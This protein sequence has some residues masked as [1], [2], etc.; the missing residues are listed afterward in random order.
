M[1]QLAANPRYQ[2]ADGERCAILSLNNPAYLAHSLAVMARR[3]SKTWRL[4]HTFSR[5]LAFCLPQGSRRGCPRDAGVRWCGGASQPLLPRQGETASPRP[6]CCHPSPLA[7][8]HAH[9][10]PPHSF[11]FAW[12]Q[13]AEQ[14]RDVR[15][16]LLLTSA[17]LLEKRADPIGKEAGLS[18]VETFGSHPMLGYPSPWS[19]SWTAEAVPKSALAAPPRTL[20]TNATAL[21]FY[22]SGSTGKPKPIPHTHAGVL[23]WARAYS[24]A[25]PDIFPEGEEASARGGSLSFT[26]Y[27]HV[28]GFVAS[29]AINLVQGRPSYV[30][31]KGGMPLPGLNVELLTRAIDELRPIVLNSVPW[32]VEAFCKTLA[33]GQDPRVRDALDSLRLLTYGGAALKPSCEGVLHLF[34]INATCSYGQTELCGPV[35]LGDL[36]GDMISLRPIGP[37]RALLDDGDTLWPL[38]SWPHGGDVPGKLV[39][40]GFGCVSRYRVDLADGKLVPAPGFVRSRENAWET[41]D[42]VSIWMGNALHRSRSQADL[43][44]QALLAMKAEALEGRG[45]GDGGE[46]GGGSEMA[47]EGAS[48]GVYDVE[49]D[50][51][52]V[53]VI[54]RMR[55]KMAAR[56]KLGGPRR[57]S[58]EQA[59]AAARAMLGEPDLSVS[60]ASAADVPVEGVEEPPQVVIGG[61]AVPD[62]PTGRIEN[63]LAMFMKNVREVGKSAMD[64]VVDELLN[65][66]EAP[67]RTRTPPALSRR[68]SFTD[69]PTS[70]AAAAAS[71]SPM[72][73]FSIRKSVSFQFGQ[74]ED[75]AERLGHDI[76]S[77]KIQAARTVVGWF[78]EDAEPMVRFACRS[79]EVLVHSTGEMTNPIPTE[80]LVL[81]RCAGH[82]RHAVFVQVAHHARGSLIVELAPDADF[83]DAAPE[84]QAAL[85]EANRDLLATYSRI[86]NRQVW[87]LR[88]PV[89]QPLELT[90]KGNV[91]RRAAIARLGVRPDDP[92]APRITLAN[93]MSPAD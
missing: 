7:L 39:L 54:D 25:L 52:V 84:L 63:S 12:Q 15:A 31:A 49:H 57:L 1:T 53:D 14:V 62:R 70:A 58:D 81:A 77:A 44:A 6:D 74:G 59:R 5:G 47:D 3:P 50:V 73:G 46:G 17:D 32:L 72:A 2:V 65:I 42:Q 51:S 27:Y 4:G 34:N 45:D 24:D 67:L 89:D 36:D 23:W 91:R 28:M 88:P 10:C 20:A 19:K 76:S 79:D 29:T 90:E 71:P 87:L 37:T 93:L 26:P 75:L 18:R 66:A 61:K 9:P 21:F 35:M 8:P 22:T 82:V 85:Q 64:A 68:P 11:G 33:T 86:S 80:T 30:L 43:R 40:E 92:I 78:A 48:A 56:G 83:A 38:A 69:A 13:L 16:V 55:E 60:A 41:G